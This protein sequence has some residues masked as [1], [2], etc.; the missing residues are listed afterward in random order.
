M[1]MFMERTVAK[2]MI[3]PP[4]LKGMVSPTSVSPVRNGDP[5]FPALQKALA[6][7]KTMKQMKAP[8]ATKLNKKK[9]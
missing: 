8:M 6:T 3:K 4:G 5:G 1:P 2:P 9:A 7:A